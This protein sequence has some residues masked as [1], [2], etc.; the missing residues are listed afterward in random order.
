MEKGGGRGACQ[1]PQERGRERGARWEALPPVRLT[2]PPPSPHHPPP[3]L[4]RLPAH[5][6]DRGIW[7][8]T[9]G[10][11]PCHGEARDAPRT[12]REAASAH[13]EQEAGVHEPC[14]APSS[15]SCVFCVCVSAGGRGV[16][17]ANPV[18][19]RASRAQWLL[20]RIVRVQT[21]GKERCCLEI[22][23]SPWLGR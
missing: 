23:C 16:P 19:C 15:P 4:L 21:K 8:G 5:K 13:G 1:R 3:P 10:E 20:T 17:C 7:R 2:P 11:A 6:D 22:R 18:S 14:M 12:T 9:R